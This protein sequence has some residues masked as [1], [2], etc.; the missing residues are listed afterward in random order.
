MSWCTSEVKRCFVCERDTSREC[1]AGIRCSGIWPKAN[2][3]QYALAA[4]E[5]GLEPTLSGLAY[6]ETAAPG[7]HSTERGTTTLADTPGDRK[8]I[9]QMAY[10]RLGD[11]LID[12]GLI[13]EDQLGPEAAE[14][15]EAPSG[16]E[17]SP[18]TSSR[19]RVHRGAG[20]CSWA[21]SSSTCRRSN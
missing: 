14:R 15:D 12:A 19:K 21:W 13:T 17:P 20:R 1:D 11:V 18:R 10:K 8:R 4:T 2:G 7:P 3:T 6:S 5:N 16:D 9:D